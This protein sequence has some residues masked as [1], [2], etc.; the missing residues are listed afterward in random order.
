MYKKIAIIIINYKDY[1]EK[2]LADCRD[3]LRAQSYPMEDVNIYI[4]DN[5]S[6][7]ISRDYIKKQFPEA[8][9][10]PRLDGNYSAANNAGIRKGLDD[11][12]EYFVIVNMDVKLDKE[13]LS[14]LVKGI[15]S[16]K[17]LGAVQS[18]MLLYPKIDEEWKN[19]KI[20]SLGN[21]MHFMGFGFT[22]SYNEPDR[23]IEGYPRIRG[24]ASGCSLIV[25]R[26]VIEKIEGYNEEYYMYHDDVELSWK[27]K[28]A[29]YELALAPK[30]VMYHKYEFSRSVKMLYYM[31]RNRYIAVFT[32]YKFPT[33]L[34]ILPALLA[35][36]LG[37]LLYSIM[38]GWFITKI[39]VY[40][41]FLKPSSWKKIKEERRKIMKYRKVDDRMIVKNLYGKVLFQEISNPILGYVANPIFN[42]YWQFVKRLIFW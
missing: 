31:E 20:N 18:K 21:L 35:M 14:E 32:F 37:M 40:G 26:E 39:R 42:L 2:F 36:D 11:G 22:S 27:M 34:L 10:I 6:S 38:N 1:A 17:E 12:C 16:G 19:P 28:L 15:E 7:D 5:S 29:G 41:Y 4:V 8:I 23:K 33:I 9:I 24:Y 13:W 25:K 3:S 30:S